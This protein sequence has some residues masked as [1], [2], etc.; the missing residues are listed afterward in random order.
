MRIARGV[1]A[2]TALVA[3]ICTVQAEPRIGFFR[4]QFGIVAF[5]LNGPVATT[6][7]KLGIGLVRGSCGW[8]RSSPRGARS[9]GA[10]PTT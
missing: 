7:A 4:S 6:L 9:R 10:A 2:L 5:D 8:T 1:V 3:G